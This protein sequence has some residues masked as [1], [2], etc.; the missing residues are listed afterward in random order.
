M[1]QLVGLTPTL[2][3]AA[4]LL[5]VV[6]ALPALPALPRGLAARMAPFVPFVTLGLGAAGVWHAFEHG[7]L[8]VKAFSSSVIRYASAELNEATEPFVIV[9]DGGSYVL[10]G[11]DTVLVMDELKKLGFSAR[12]VRLAA[13]G[14]NHF[15]RYRMQ[16]QLVARLRPKKPH[17]R[18]IYLAEIHSSYDNRPITQFLENLETERSYHYTTLSNAWAAVAALRTPG[19]SPTEPW[20]WLLFRHALVNTFSVGAL[21]RYAPEAEIPMGGG[22]VSHHRPRKMRFPGTERQIRSLARPVPGL[23]LPWLRDV[24]DKRTHELWRGYIDDFA[25]FGLPSTTVEQLTYVRQLCGAAPRT[26][27]APSDPELLASLDEAKY[28]RDKGHMTAKGAAI[29]SRWFARQLV[30]TGIVAR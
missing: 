25:Y 24:R 6:G 17:Q 13:G 14:A 4:A 7:G 11:V 12:A 27:I 15:E 28:W 9:I 30:R 22:R 10:N 2:I 26:C 20:R 1:E 23:M 5:V 3:V 21:S 18:W 29:Y 19:I 16:Q 8:M